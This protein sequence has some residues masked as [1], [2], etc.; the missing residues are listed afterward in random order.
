MSDLSA[1]NSTAKKKPF[2]HRG[3]RPRVPEICLPDGRTLIPR[4]DFARH[5][6]G[7]DERTARRWNLP[8]TYVGGVAYVDLNGSLEIIGATVK[9]R[10]QPPKRMAKRRRGR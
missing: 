1:D 6:M 7:V 2:R 9:R 10:N 8:T 5:K 3:P 4:E